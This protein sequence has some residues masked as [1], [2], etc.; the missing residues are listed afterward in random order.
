MARTIE[1]VER[2]G[3]AGYVE[4]PAGRIRVW[5]CG[6]G[7]PLVFVHGLLTNS[8]LWRKVVPTLAEHH[9]CIVPDWPLGSHPESMRADA[10]LSPDGLVAVTVAVLDGLGLERAVL[11]GN[12]TGGALSQLVAARHS[13]RVT[14]LVLTNCDAYDNFPPRIFAPLMMAARVPGG[15]AALAQLLRI[16][17]LWR[18]P[19]AF[20]W[21]A[22]HPLHP[23]VVT[24]W[25]T[26]A[27]TDGGV[28]RDLAK[29]LQGIDPR[30]TLDAAR[31]LRSFERPVLLAWAPE[32]RLFPIAHAE[33][34]ATELPDATVERVD[35]SYTFVPED[36]PARLAQLIAA[37]VGDRVEA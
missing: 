25:L 32:D 31:A 35:D 11:V 5:E 36:Q 26:P 10:D 18:L 21:L 6:A 22:K 2:V 7:T 20:G 30:Y 1:A 14:A 3:T 17:A 13:D 27:R 33:R 34:L 37:F 23:G 16:R 15:L 24:A 19:V 29:A 9:R 12:D 28:R 8:L 4:T